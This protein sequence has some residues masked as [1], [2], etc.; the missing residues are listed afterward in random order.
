[1]DIN[2]KNTNENKLKNKSKI[3][4]G[5]IILVTMLGVLII[6]NFINLQKAK[7]IEKELFNIKA[8]LYMNS[9]S[10]NGYL[11]R[12]IKSYVPSIESDVSNIKSDV[13]SIES[14]VSAIRY[15]Y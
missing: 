15:G 2:I 3:T 9:S 7:S 12:R 13:S 6:S 8:G 10:D 11:L 5:Q 14:D 4:L 1:M